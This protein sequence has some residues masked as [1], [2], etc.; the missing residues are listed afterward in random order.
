M[1]THCLN[2]YVHHFVLTIN[3]FIIVMHHN[4]IITADCFSVGC[5][6]VIMPSN[7]EGLP[8]ADGNWNHMSVKRIDNKGYITMNQK[9]TGGP[10]V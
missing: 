5:A 2:L 9:F 1:V 8:Y 10:I 6:A 7:D 4:A 3:H